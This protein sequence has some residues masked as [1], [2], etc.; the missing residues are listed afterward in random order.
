MWNTGVPWRFTNNTP[1]NRV[2]LCWSADRRRRRRQEHG[3]P[4]SSRVARRPLATGVVDDHSS[5]TDYRHLHTLCTHINQPPLPGPLINDAAD[6][7]CSR[8]GRQPPLPFEVLVGFKRNDCALYSLNT[9]G[10]NSVAHKP[11]FHSFAPH[12]EHNKQNAAH[13]QHRQWQNVVGPRRRLCG[14]NVG[15]VQLCCR[16]QSMCAICVCR[17]CIGCR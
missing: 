16:Q 6:D 11:V 2:A 3:D 1:V 14:G 4:N 15:H 7:A 10:A 12:Q 9:G 5:M 8:N 13:D 17:G